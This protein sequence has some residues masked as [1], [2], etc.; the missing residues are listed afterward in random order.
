M[1][2]YLV[3]ICLF[4]GLSFQAQAQDGSTARGMIENCNV[5]VQL[6][7]NPDRV[8]TADLP[9]ATFCMG[10][11]QGIVDGITAVNDDM[12]KATGNGRL[13]APHC[14]ADEKISIG[15]A[16]S[17]FLAYADLK[18]ERL[19]GGE[20]QVMFEALAFAYPCD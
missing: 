16:V 9:S 18:P 12:E 8:S 11:A 15:E 10:W 14:I 3:A 1:P 5:A 4:A 6:H 20:G 2:H 19:A 17:V 7:E 13:T